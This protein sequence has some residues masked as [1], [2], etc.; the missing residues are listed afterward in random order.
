MATIEVLTGPP[1]DAGAALEPE[2]FRGL[3]GELSGAVKLRR[4]KRELISQLGP[5]AQA[6]S[7]LPACCVGCEFLAACT[8]RKLACYDFLAWVEDRPFEAPK[9]IRRVATR[10]MY[11]H[12][13]SGE[14]GK[15]S[16]RSLKNMRKA[17]VAMHR[18]LTD[19]P[20]T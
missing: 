18:R 11:E 14:E 2:P 12:V 7:E 19:A 15:A 9:E 20:S 1:R 5:L 6:T 10:E 13:F 4:K 16:A 8:A 3:P 17:T